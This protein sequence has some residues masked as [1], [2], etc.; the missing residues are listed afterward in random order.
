MIP[1]EKMSGADFERR[2][3]DVLHRELGLGGLARFLRLYRSGSGD[4]S[5]DRHLWI[6]GLTIQEIMAEVKRRQALESARS[7]PRSSNN[8]AMIGGTDI[9]VKGATPQDADLILWTMRTEWPNGLVQAGDSLEAVPFREVRLPIS[10]PTALIIYRDAASFQAWRLSGAT[11]ENQDAMMHVIVAAD[12][13]TI[14]VDR[15]DS[16]L[17]SL[18]REML[19]SVT[20]NR[21]LP[22]G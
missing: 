10:G 20:M 13:V 11:P 15:E 14:V 1:S 18:A 12:S 17:A 9:V 22:T 5:R 2:A 8:R 16:P 3:F 7:T 21:L 6:D 4:Y 19:E